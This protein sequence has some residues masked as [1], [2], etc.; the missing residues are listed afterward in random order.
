MS[1]D[2]PI[3]IVCLARAELLDVRPSWGGGKQNATSIHIEPLIR[4][5]SAEMIEDLLGAPRFPLRSAR[6]SWAASEGTPL[7]LEE[8][9]A[10]LVDN[11]G[12]RYGDAG[13]AAATDLVGVSIRPT[14]HALPAARL[15]GLAADER[16]CSSCRASSGRRSGAQ[17]SG[18]SRL[19]NSP[20]VSTAGS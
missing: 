7:F 2:A 4:D 20:T 16:P 5:E 11:G 17:R 19:P 18:R 1:R 6:G 3:R 15:D 12:I 14:I 13:R 10:M 8:M 9:I